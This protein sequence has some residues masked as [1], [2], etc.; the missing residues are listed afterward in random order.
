MKSIIFPFLA[1]VMCITLPGCRPSYTESNVLPIDSIMMKLNDFASFRLTTDLTILSENQK[2]MIPILIE[3]A[4]IMNDIFW[5]EAYGDQEAFLESL[6]TDAEKRLGMINYGPWERLNNN[7]PFVEGFGPKPPGANFYPADLTKNEFE[8]FDAADKTSSYTLIRRDNEGKLQVVPYHEAFRERVGTASRL[9]H[10]AAALAEDPGFGKYLELRAEALLTDNYYM[11]DMAWMDMKENLIDFVA[12]PIETYE[13]QLYGYKAAHEAYI[14]IKDLEW[15]ER[16]SKF[17][18]L[19]PMLQEQ[20]PADVAYKSET[21]GSSSDLGVYDAIY[22]AGDCNA[23]AKT[24]AINLPNDERVQQAKGSRR[25]QLKNAMQAKFDQILVPI[26]NELI[27]QSDLEHITFDAF[28]TNTMFHEIAHGL[29]CNHTINGKGTVREALKEHYTTLEESK[30]DILGL[31]LVTKLT[32]MG[33]MEMDLTDSYTT[34][35]AGIF[36]SVRFGASSAHGKANLI[37][38]NYFRE[39]EAFTIRAD[40]QYVV[41]FVKMQE[42]VVSLS[43]LIITIQGDGDYDKAAWL[44]ETYG[45]MDGQLKASLDRIEQQDIPVDIVFEQGLDVLGL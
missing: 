32:E 26:A 10:E 11:S 23:G 16:L 25:L 9:M 12:G 24:I 4:Q 44:I 19:L 28:F 1:A 31:Y 27:T 2:K 14:L 34:F 35:L 7:L 30:A 18:A 6:E 41:D 22:Y 29:G 37:R 21:P 38:F 33:E 20:L 45:V 17:E 42:A 40:G 13:D 15:T 3:V 8:Q 39:K 43:N 36:R 5:A